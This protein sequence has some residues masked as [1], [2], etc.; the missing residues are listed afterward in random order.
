MT[1]DLVKVPVYREADGTKTLFLPACRLGVGYEIG[2]RGKDKQ[3]H[4]QNYW[5]ALAKLNEMSTPRFRRPNRNGRHGTVTCEPGDVEAVSR[6]LIE[7]E[8]VK[9]GG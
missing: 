9:V 7:A 5:N 4:I 8:R 6:A 3:K 1:T 2:A